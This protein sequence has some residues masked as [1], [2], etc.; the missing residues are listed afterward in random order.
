[1]AAWRHGRRQTRIPALVDANGDLTFDHDSMSTVFADRF[2]AHDLG[3]IPLSFPDNPPARPV[4]PF[5]PIMADEAFALLS[6]TS[7]T[8]SPRDSGIGWALLKRGWGPVSETLT[9]IF[10]ACITL[11]HHPAVWKNVVVVVILKPDRPD[12]TQ[13]KAHRPIS[14]LETMSKLLEKVVAQC[15]QHDIVTEELIPTT[16]FGCRDIRHFY[17]IFSFLSCH[18]D[19]ALCLPF[20]A[21][22]VCI[23]RLLI[24]FTLLLFSIL[25]SP[26]CCCAA[27]LIPSSYCS[28]DS[29]FA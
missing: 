10:N 28:C 9:A 12:Y 11:G 14:L 1:V 24:H 7:N 16:Q 2:F 29:L 18:Q 6:R 20:S 26:L 15:M 27:S 22:Y 5:A 25:S 3:D 8:S 4:R 13:A 17:L 23:S 19:D 21:D